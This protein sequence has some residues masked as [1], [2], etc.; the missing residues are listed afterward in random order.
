MIRINYWTGLVPRLLMAG[1][2]SSLLAA[3]FRGYRS[4]MLG[5]SQSKLVSTYGQP[6]RLIANGSTASVYL[7]WHPTGDEKYA[8]KRF[9]DQAETTSETA[10]TNR[11]MGEAI[12]DAH[13][14]PHSSILKMQDFF[15]DSGK[16]YAVMRYIPTTLFDRTLGNGDE[17]SLDDKIC[18][19]IRILDGIRHMHSE[20][21]AHL[22]LKLNN[23]LLED[24]MW[25]KIIDFGTSQVDWTNPRVENWI[26]GKQERWQLRSYL[27]FVGSVVS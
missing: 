20:G 3:W 4:P 6:V 18:V 10:Y 27:P 1:I 25:P 9:K 13:L 23:I 7:H 14:S 5:T 26:S 17:L 11:V 8:I 21:V 19:W 22:D 2:V 12:V 24:G 15:Q 16:W